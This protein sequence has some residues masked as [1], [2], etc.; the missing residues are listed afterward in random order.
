MILE[1]PPDKNHA[2]VVEKIVIEMAPLEL[3]GFMSLFTWIFM[4]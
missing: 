4:D 1:F 2:G 3:V